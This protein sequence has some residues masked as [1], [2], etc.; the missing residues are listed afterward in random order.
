MI[1]ENENKND[2]EKSLNASQRPFSQIDFDED[3]ECDNPEIRFNN[4]ISSEVSGT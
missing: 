3:V 1:I 4:E 2:S